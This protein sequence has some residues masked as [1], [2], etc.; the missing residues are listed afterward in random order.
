MR[1]LDRTR[2]SQP[3]QEWYRAYILVV[4][5][6]IQRNHEVNN[7][8]KRLPGYCAMHQKTLNI[9]LKKVEGRRQTDP[10]QWLHATADPEDRALNDN[11]DD[12]D[13]KDD[14]TGTILT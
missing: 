9:A 7:M 12:D 11:G 14:H 4:D 10:T 1:A 8:R 2:E 13:A 5:H 6:T 3:P